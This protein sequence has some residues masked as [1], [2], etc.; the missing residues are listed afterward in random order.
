MGVSLYIKVC[1][2]LSVCINTCNPMIMGGQCKNVCC[3]LINL[4]GN[5]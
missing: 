4:L 2:A 5:K 3:P 1:V